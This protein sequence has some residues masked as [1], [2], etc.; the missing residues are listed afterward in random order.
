MP[1]ATVI[2]DPNDCA[3]CVLIADICDYHR[4]FAEGWDALA[5]YVA[6][7]AEPI[8]YDEVIP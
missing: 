6:S 2:S 5:G 7:H 3:D 4:G 1:D 8:S